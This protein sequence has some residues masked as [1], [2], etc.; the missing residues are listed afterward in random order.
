MEIVIWSN[1]QVK[2]NLAEFMTVEMSTIPGG[3]KRQLP[4]TLENENGETF[5]CSYDMEGTIPGGAT[6]KL[7]EE[8]TECKTV[9]NNLENDDVEVEGKTKK[10][11]RMVIYYY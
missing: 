5:S 10:I 6:L 2:R 8:L 4:L 3:R 11:I 9:L 1:V 7:L